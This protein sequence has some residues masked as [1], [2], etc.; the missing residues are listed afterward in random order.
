MMR[1][2]RMGGSTTDYSG[3]R[4][5]VDQVLAVASVTLGLILGLFPQAR[6]IHVRRDPVETGLSIYRN[7]FP[8]FATFAHR[9]ADIGHYYGE[10]ARLMAHWDSVLKGRFMTVQYEELVADFD[11]GMQLPPKLSQFSAESHILRITVRPR[12]RVARD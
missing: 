1:R 2:E 5:V 8:K 9:L 3:Y 11:S 7:E 12:E 4:S 6:I 10:Y